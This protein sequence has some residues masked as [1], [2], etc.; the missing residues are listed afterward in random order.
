MLASGKQKR[1]Q[2]GRGR[3]AGARVR[4]SQNMTNWVSA[5]SSL[6]PS[7]DLFVL[8][9]IQTVGSMRDNTIEFQPRGIDVDNQVMRTYG[10]DDDVIWG[11][12]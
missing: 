5:S 8:L 10:N 6:M 1:G 11:K 7:S 12:H 9:R 2:C 3:L 4:F